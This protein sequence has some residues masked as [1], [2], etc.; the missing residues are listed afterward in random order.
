MSVYEC[1]SYARL[2][3][4]PDGAKDVVGRSVEVGGVVKAMAVKTTMRYT[5]HS[6][7]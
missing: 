4:K 3:N 7:E 1:V 2:W 5:K 6:L